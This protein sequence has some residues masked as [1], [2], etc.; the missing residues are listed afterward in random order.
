MRAAPASAAH[1]AALPLPDGAGEGGFG[2]S[3]GFSQP[4]NGRT[5]HDRA[6][7]HLRSCASK[8]FMRRCRNL[9]LLVGSMSG[10]I[11]GGVQPPMAVLELGSHRTV[12]L[13]VNNAPIV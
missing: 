9:P 11:Q 8:R 1:E 2:R 5:H 13:R 6:A 12:R 3:G 4:D 10:S 7:H